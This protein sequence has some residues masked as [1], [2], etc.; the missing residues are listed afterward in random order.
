MTSEEYERLEKD[1]KFHLAIEELE[2]D[3]LNKGIKDFYSSRSLL[4]LS[5]KQEKWSGCLIQ[6]LF[7]VLFTIA[8]IVSIIVYLLRQ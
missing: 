6:S 4:Y 2:P 7:I 8:L 3:Q 5:K 1:H